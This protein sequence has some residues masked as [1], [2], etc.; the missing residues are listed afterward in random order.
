MT[1]LM[2]KIHNGKTNEVIERPMTEDE[3]ASHLEYIKS[4]EKQKML[5]EQ[6]TTKRQALLD[7]L[8]ISEEE[9]KLLL[10]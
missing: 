2:I 1:N 7:R 5:M 6:A 3:Y 8:G 9:A 10:L 4:V